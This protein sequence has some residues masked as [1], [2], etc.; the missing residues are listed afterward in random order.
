MFHNQASKDET[1]YDESVG[2]SRQRL[3]LH[4][5]HSMQRANLLGLVLDLAPSRSVESLC[6]LTW[7]DQA[8]FTL[9]VE[10]VLLLE[11]FR[12]TLSTHLMR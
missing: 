7:A 2:N 12:Q 1:S 3:T 5:S 6:C 10:D 8:G 4:P 11:G 9:G